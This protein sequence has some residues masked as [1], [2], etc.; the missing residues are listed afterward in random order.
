[1]MLRTALFIAIVG[2]AAITYEWLRDRSPRGQS[3]VTPPRPP[4]TGKELI[5]VFIGSTDCAPSKQPGFNVVVQQASQKIANI[6][7]ARGLAFNRVGV[8]LSGSPTDGIK[9][10]SDFGVFDESVTG[11]GVDEFRGRGVHLAGH[12][13][14]LRRAPASRAAAQAG[15]ITM[16]LDC[17]CRFS[18]RANRWRGPNPELDCCWRAP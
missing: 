4:R 9:F 7:R 1:M 15:C 10:L 5:F 6:A 18:D 12:S 14:V 2:G 16:W 3:A 8:A 17:V 13:W 11:G